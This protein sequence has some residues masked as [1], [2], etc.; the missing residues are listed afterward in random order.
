MKHLILLCALC[1]STFVE[2][3]KPEKIYPNARD[4]KPIAYFKEQSALWKKETEKDP[5]NADAWYNYYYANRNLCF[6]DTTR[7]SEEKHEV[8]NKL[9][10]EMGK[11]VPNSYEYNLAMWQNGGWNMELLPYLK[12]AES[13]GPDRS[14]HLDFSIVLSEIAG[15]MEDRDKYSVKKEEAGQFSTGMLYYNYN[16]LMGLDPN[17]ILVTSGDNDTYPVWLLQSRGIRKDVNIV[18]VGMLYLEEYRKAMFARLGIADYTFPKSDQPD[19]LKAW[20]DNYKRR[21]IEHLVQNS[22]GHPVYVA[23]TAAGHGYIGSIEDKLY[24]TGLAYRYSKTP[25]DNMAILKR[26]FE[27]QYALDYIEKAFYSDISPALVKMINCNYILPM[28][29]LYDHYKTAGEVQKQEAIKGKLLYIC[30]GKPDE[31]EIRKHFGMK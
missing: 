17:A 6:N 25:L 13:L 5:K 30:K 3:Q 18:H 29:K 23:L 21:I 12:K 11:A 24:L 31:Q 4:H 20:R 14:E 28:L 1:F 7:G 19:S 10:A 16:V 26:N 9:L 8:V 27:Q 15:N 22:K 2:A